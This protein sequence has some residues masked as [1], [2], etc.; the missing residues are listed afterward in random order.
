M[1]AN[2][3]ILTNPV[4]CRN[5]QI[6]SYCA[7]DTSSRKSNICQGDSGGPLMYLIDGRW[8]LYGISSFV[9]RI[10]NNNCVNTLPSFYTIVPN[11]LNWI[12]INRV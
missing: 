3:T 5:F 9:L 11:Y 1:Q 10:N 7:L 2:L 12:S 6:Q 8:N 4:T